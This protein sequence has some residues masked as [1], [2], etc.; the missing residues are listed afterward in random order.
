MDVGDQF[1][2][3]HLIF[4]SR[5][6]RACKKEKDLISDFYLIRKDRGAFPSSYSY[7]CKSCTINRI[8]SSR[9]TKVKTR[10]WEYPDW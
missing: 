10:G 2:L 3:E 9:K 1:S 7:E 8:I 4:S 5:T 6:C